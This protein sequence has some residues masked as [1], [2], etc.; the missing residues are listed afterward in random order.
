[1]LT[2]STSLAKASGTHRSDTASMRLADRGG[3]T[4][5]MTTN[6]DLLLEAA[7]K[8]L[9]VPVETYALGS[10]PRP[11]RRKEFAGVFHIHGALSRNPA[12]FSDLVLTDQ[13][14]GEFYLRRRVVPDLMGARRT[15]SSTAITNT[16]V[17]C[18]SMSSAAAI[19]CSPNADPPTSMAPGVRAT[20]SAASSR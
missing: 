5:I 15:P 17:S 3:A 8:R 11:T 9:R 18:P 4:T 14:F 20:R 16:A 1:M 6:F 19:S 7:A 2:P 13:D 10:I 12:R